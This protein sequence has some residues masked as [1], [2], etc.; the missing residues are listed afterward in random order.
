MMHLREPF[1]KVPGRKLRVIVYGR[2]STE[3]QNYDSVEHQFAYCTRFL[4]DHGLGDSDASITFLEDREISGE[5]LS[6][7]GI[8]AIWAAVE[9]RDFDLLIAEDASRLY[10]NESACIRLGEMMVD[11]GIRLICINDYVDSAE[12]DWHDRLSEAARHH[13]KSN[14]FVSARIKRAQEANFRAGAAMGGL[15]PG[16]KRRAT[17]EATAREPERGP[18]FDSPDENEFP[19]IVEAY[20][21]VG[22]GEPLWSVALFLNDAGLRKGA[23]ARSNV[24]TDRD[25][26]ALMQ[27]LGD[28]TG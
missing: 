13:A 1:K 24:W 4:A 21:R 26:R 12:R 17:H 14:A 16:Y 10:R 6:R 8:D 5:E 23:T 28:R 9:R 11:R 15:L 22:A 7:P 3:E 18:F 25:V 27:H 20:D 2:Y 19:L